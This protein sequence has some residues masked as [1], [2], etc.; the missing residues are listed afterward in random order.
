MAGY[1]FVLRD[2]THDPAGMEAYSKKAW[3]AATEKLELV[4]GSGSFEVLE[5]SPADAVVLLRFPTL[6]D[7]QEWYDGD[8]Y[9][10]ARPLRQAA[11]DCRVLL[12]EGAS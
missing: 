3:A 6:A 1:I 2:T 4:A 10:E 11:S 9:I 8:A 5:G 7:A 12:F